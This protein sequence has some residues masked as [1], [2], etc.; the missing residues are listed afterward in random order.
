MGR[1][2]SYR[3]RQAQRSQRGRAPAWRLQDIANVQVAFADVSPER[4][5]RIMPTRTA[6]R[7]CRGA[8]RRSRR[9]GLSRECA[10]SESVLGIPAET[11]THHT[12]TTAHTTNKPSVQQ[13]RPAEECWS[14]GYKGS[15]TAQ[16]VKG[17]SGCASLA[18]FAP[19]ASKTAA[20]RGYPSTAGRAMGA[21]DLRRPGS[22][23]GPEALPEQDRRTGS[24]RAAEKLLAAFCSRSRRSS[25]GDQ[26]PVALSESSS[27]PP[28]PKY[29][30][31]YLVGTAPW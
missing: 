8:A 13:T 4:P 20:V 7:C 26:T 6:K 10:S 14:D 29:H 19:C 11:L 9:P 23:H 15:D 2:E 3:L 30:E 24:K 16:L 27:S 22:C 12:S 1:E 28:R 5:E 18:R 25:A 21:Q 31:D 17:A